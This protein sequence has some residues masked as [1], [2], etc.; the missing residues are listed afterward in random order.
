MPDVKASG[1][2]ILECHAILDNLDWP[3]GTLEE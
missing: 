1:L 2:T 3:M